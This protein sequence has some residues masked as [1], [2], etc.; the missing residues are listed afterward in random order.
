MG[1]LFPIPGLGI[2]QNHEKIHK[3]CQQLQQPATSN[4]DKYESSSGIYKLKNPYRGGPSRWLKGPPDLRH[5]SLNWPAS[6]LRT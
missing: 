2:L 4:V 3:G 6:L 1:E 5:Q